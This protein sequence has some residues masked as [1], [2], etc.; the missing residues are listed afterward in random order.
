M[1]AHPDARPTAGILQF[2]LKQVLIGLPLR[3]NHD[4][5]LVRRRKRLCSPLI[6]AHARVTAIQ[7]LRHR[8]IVVD[9]GRLGEELARLTLNNVVLVAEVLRELGL[10]AAVRV[11]G[12]EGALGAVLV[13]GEADLA[14][15]RLVVGHLE[16]IV[17]LIE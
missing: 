6:Y 17:L 9:E 14:A 16:I 8:R 13:L 4:A 12:V 5:H 2:I 11:V 7:L 3:L 1:P 15:L 10:G